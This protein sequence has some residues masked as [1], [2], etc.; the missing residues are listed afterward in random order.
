M[1]R[2][3]SRNSFLSLSPF[4]PIRPEILVVL[5]RGFLCQHKVCVSFSWSANNG[6]FRRM[7]PKKNVSYDTDFA[8]PAMPSMS[9][10]DCFRVG[11]LVS[12]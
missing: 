3:A 8:G 5:Q 11:R 1:T 9:Y 7:A 4:V 6:V 12:V 2:A 10:L